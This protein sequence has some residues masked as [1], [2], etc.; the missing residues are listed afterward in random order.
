MWKW[1]TY[2]SSYLTTWSR[3][4]LN[5]FTVAQLIN[6]F[7]AFIELEMSLPSHKSLPMDPIPSKMNP[8]HFLIPYFFNIH[9][10]IILPSI[11]RSEILYAFSSS[12]S[13]VPHILLELAVSTKKFPQFAIFAS[14]L[15][16]PISLS[17]SG[18]NIDLSTLFYIPSL[19]WQT[20]IHTH[21]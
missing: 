4:F 1:A 20:E 17:L 5:K 9:F 13:C 11:S 12:L 14:L 3:V 19:Q 7:P 10:G 18:S 6:K 2:T 15:L 16:L 21:R 8:V